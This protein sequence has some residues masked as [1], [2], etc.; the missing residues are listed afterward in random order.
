MFWP[1][2]SS[3]CFNTR[4]RE[5]F[6][7]TWSAACLSRDHPSQVSDRYSS[8]GKKA[9]PKERV[10]SLFLYC[11]YR[12]IIREMTVRYEIVCNI[13]VETTLYNNQINVR[14]LIGHCSGKPMEKSRVLRIVI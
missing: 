5:L 1:G 6:G 13:V 3:V 10:V 7:N 9:K 11:R 12:G 4:L 2:P 14:A 8:I